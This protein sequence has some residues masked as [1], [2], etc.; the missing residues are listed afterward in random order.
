MAVLNADNEETA[1]CA[2]ERGKAQTSATEPYSACT[3]LPC[4]LSAHADLLAAFAHLLEALA[5]L[6][7]AATQ[8]LHICLMCSA[9]LCIA[10][11]SACSYA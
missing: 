6:F 7:L 11:A 8:R 10:T 4:H 3:S 5:H 2:L 9:Y 1:N